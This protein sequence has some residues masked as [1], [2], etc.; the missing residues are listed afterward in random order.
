MVRKLNR[1]TASAPQ[2]RP[3]RIL[4]FGKG[5][6][7]R[8]FAD[9]MT[10]V[11]NET[12]SFNA[13]IQI[14]QVNSTETDNRFADQEGLYHLVTNG[15]RDGQPVREIRL[16]K[17]VASVINPVENYSSYLK[18]AENP[19]LEFIISNTTEAGIAFDQCDKAPDVVAKSF[20]GKLTALLYHRYKFF[21]GDISKSLV[22]L[23]CELIENN[24]EALRNVIAEYISLWKLQKGFG[25]WIEHTLFCNTLV[26]RIVPGFPKE[27]VHKIWEQTGF[28]DH[29]VV[30]AEPY[31][32]WVIQPLS[33]SGEYARR[34]LSAFAQAKTGLNVRIV[35]DLVPYRTSKV[36]I[37]NGAHTCMVPI[38]YLRGQRTVKEAVDDPFTGNFVRSAIEEE[39]IPTLDMPRGELRCFAS[40][41]IERFQNPFIRHELRSIALN[42]VSKFQVRVLP[43]LLEYV[44]RTN[45]LPQRLVYSLA[46]LIMFY[47]GEWRGESLPV[48]DTPQVVAFFK[49]VW[50]EK[51]PRV[52]AQ[53]VLSNKEL[54]KTDL[55][56]IQ[57][58]ASL[59]ERHLGDGMHEKS[60]K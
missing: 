52:I 45:Q 55:T 29:L 1:K 10:D 23:P 48:N 36:R 4:Q 43:S 19:D 13:A 26:D 20:P 5:N 49:D 9:W 16:I 53:K 7:L 37:L 15:I 22:I 12:T 25:E 39:I 2:D 31:H 35:S 11:L 32:L 34:R 56:Q 46:S 14:V 42:S 8:A 44:T 38:G 41:V 60:G 28:E 47:K 57:G 59:V 40:D 18:A 3:V 27:D 33:D 21:K 58:L 51:D 17:S 24:G 50:N 6:F 54:W 30:T